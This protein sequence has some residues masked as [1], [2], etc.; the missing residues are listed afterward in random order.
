MKAAVLVLGALALVGC[1]SPAPG[2]T[3]RVL[4]PIP[5]ECREPVP[6]RPAC[7][8]NCCCLGAHPCVLLRVALAEIVRR[9]GYEM[10]LRAALVVCTAPLAKK[11]SPTYFYGGLIWSTRVG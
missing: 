7:P 5:V 9:E 2:P 3:V 6:D 4:V 10:Q 1:A 8:P 11:I